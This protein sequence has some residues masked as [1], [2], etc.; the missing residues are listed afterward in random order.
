MNYISDSNVL[1]SILQREKDQHDY[2]HKIFEGD[3][4]DKPKN[5]FANN[6]TRKDMESDIYDIFSSGTDFWFIY[7]GNTR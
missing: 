6:W 1:S 5:V 7:C 4:I 2:L 3:Q